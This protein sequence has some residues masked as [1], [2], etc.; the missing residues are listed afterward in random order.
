MPSLPIGER[1]DGFGDRAH[2]ITAGPSCPHTGCRGPSGAETLAKEAGSPP[3]S[4]P[5]QPNRRSSH[6]SSPSQPHGGSRDP[7]GQ[8]GRASLHG[9]DVG[10]LSG[11][12]SSRTATVHTRCRVSVATGN[13]CWDWMVARHL[14]M[15]LARMPS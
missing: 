10:D 6:G 15:V 11:P 1:L 4:G 7:I 2:R 14:F 8:Q 13:R 3:S 12:Y 5:A 9:P